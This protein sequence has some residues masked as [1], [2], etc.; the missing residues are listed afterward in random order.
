MIAFQNT[1]ARCVDEV[2]NSFES[3]VVMP[4][5]NSTLNISLR[6]VHGLSS[7]HHSLSPGLEP[8]VPSW[9]LSWVIQSAVSHFTVKRGTN[10]LPQ[11][12]HLVVYL[13]G[14]PKEELPRKGDDAVNP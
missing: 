10:S 6:S 8:D 11:A 13:L 12:L 14:S 9:S 3:N 5:R 7:S 2:R 1:T 4:S